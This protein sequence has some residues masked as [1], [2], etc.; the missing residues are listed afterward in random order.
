VTWHE[1]GKGLWLGERVVIEVRRHWLVPVA[2]MLV[3][4]PLMLV[5]LAAVLAA[6]ARA[7]PGTGILPLALG[8]TVAGLW[9]AIPMVRWSSASLTLTDRRV[10]LTA[11]V[12]TRSRIVISFDA[13]LAVGTRQ[14]LLGRVFGYGTIHLGTTSYPLPVSFSRVPLEG[15]RDRLLAGLAAGG[16]RGGFD[17]GL[18]RRRA[19]S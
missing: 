11:G 9:V 18:D 4:A 15:V 17:P 1:R 14:S 13:I 7:D 5:V 19:I 12:L 8:L 2:E 6:A 16:G 3:S 10:I